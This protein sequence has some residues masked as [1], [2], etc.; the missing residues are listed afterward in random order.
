[1]HPLDRSIF[2]LEI[3]GS[4]ANSMPSIYPVYFCTSCDFNEFALLK[5]IV[6]CWLKLSPLVSTHS[7]L[8]DEHLT[9][10]ILEHKP[11]I[12]HFNH[13]IWKRTWR[14]LFLQQFPAHLTNPK[15]N[16][17]GFL[18]LWLD[19]KTSNISI[20]SFYIFFQQAFNRYLKL[21]KVIHCFFA[22]LSNVKS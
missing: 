17:L 2:L 14:R 18:P 19:G 20:R 16:L 4:S 10:S 11:S 7:L 22:P 8:V 21:C 9:S 5:E 12:V 3:L 15:G 13:E 6:T 1:M